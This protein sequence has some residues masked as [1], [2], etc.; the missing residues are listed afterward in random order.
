MTPKLFLLNGMG[1]GPQIFRKLAPLLPRCELVE[2]MSP[3]NGASI[4]EYARQ[5]AERIETDQPCDVLG[6][7]FGGIVAQELAPLIGAKH[8]FVVSSI[9]SASELS[10][11]VKTMRMLPAEARISLMK[12]AGRIA[13][14]WPRR[15][16]SATVRLRKFENDDGPWFC[17]A[18]SA[19]LGWKPTQACG[20]ECVVRIHG[21]RDET[22]PAGADRADHVIGGAGH[23][24]AL[25]HAEILAAIVMKYR[26]KPGGSR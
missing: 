26:T 25:T 3:K 13:S 19:V 1:G 10:F 14:A 6:V 2:W 16:S 17:W 22:F 11:G 18:S 5:L 23:M 8:C 15:P 24:L 21:D 12:S 7:S 4:P 9:N 20:G